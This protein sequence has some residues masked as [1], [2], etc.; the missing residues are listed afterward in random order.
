MRLLRWFRR[1]SPERQ[2]PNCLERWDF[3]RHAWLPEG[4]IT[5]DTGPRQVAYPFEGSTVSYVH[6]TARV[7]Y[8]ARC[9]RCGFYTEFSEPLVDGNGVPW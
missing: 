3:G 6:K 4:R 1:R 8:P 2:P 7:T 5:R 9:S